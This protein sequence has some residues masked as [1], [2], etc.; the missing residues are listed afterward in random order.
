MQV[1]RYLTGPDDASFCARVSAALQNGWQL[2]GSPT[3]SF[4]GERII[5]GQ[6]IVKEVG[7]AYQPDRPLDTY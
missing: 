5:C 1:Y 3:L 4:N 7:D 6:A 2:Y